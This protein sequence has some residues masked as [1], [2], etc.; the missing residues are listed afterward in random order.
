MKKYTYSLTINKA[1]FN[2]G[3]DILRTIRRATPEETPWYEKSFLADATKY[4][5]KLTTYTLKKH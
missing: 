1:V 4:G 2:I 5:P 3:P